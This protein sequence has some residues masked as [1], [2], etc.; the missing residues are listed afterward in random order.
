MKAQEIARL[1]EGELYG[2]PSYE[3]KFLTSLENL[4]YGGIS[5]YTGNDEN[6]LKNLEGCVITRVTYKK[7]KLVVIKVDNPKLAWAKFALLFKKK[8]YPKENKLCF[9]HPKAKIK[10]NVV[11]YPFVFIDEDVEIDEGTVIYSNVVIMNKVKIGKKVVIGPC[12]VIGFEGFG[13]VKDKNSYIHIPHLGGVVIQD[14]VEIGAGVTIDRGTITDTVI[15]EGTK[16]DNLCHIAHNVKIGKNCII[17]AQSG[18]AGSTI[19]G[20][21]V[22]IAGQCG[23]KEH[24][25]VGNNVKILAKS[26]VYKNIPDNSVYSGIPARPHEMTLKALAR[27]FKKIDHN[28]R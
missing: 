17:A 6:V 21:N 18:I 10:K 11:I 19:I 23:I 26:A 14:C 3:V 9:I 25:R 2:D 28:K 13:Y 12:S 27:I 24:V 1:V 8:E 5:F 16:I 7:E 20:D 4:R 22:I 15:G